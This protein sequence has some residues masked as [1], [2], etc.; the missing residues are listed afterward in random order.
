[1]NTPT[2][3]PPMPEKDLSELMSANAI[4]WDLE[5]VGNKAILDI[6]GIMPEFKAA[7][8]VKDPIKIEA[9]IQTKKEK[10]QAELG[11]SPD[12]GKIVCS[13]LCNDQVEHV[14]KGDDEKQIIQ[15]TWDVM[16][17][18]RELVTFNGKNYDLDWL[19]RRSWYWGIKPTQHYD[20]LP[21]RTMNHHDLRLILSH[22]NK[23]A[24]G[25]LKMYAKLKLN[26]DII[27]D[28]GSVQEQYDSGLIDEIA[29][30]GLSDT[31]T[32]WM[33]FKSLIGFYI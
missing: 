33:L 29:E 15:D 22:G 5:T 4:A 19:L 13:C 10:W 3:P 2:P 27:G 14:F 20:F 8:N 9:Q 25:K 17:D 32:T 7:S 31:R 16:K 24:K 1:M 23:T 18:W 26:I 21:Y 6:P 11:L 28:G 12:Y 30:H